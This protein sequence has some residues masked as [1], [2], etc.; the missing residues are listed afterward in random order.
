MPLKDDHYVV[1]YQ[2]IDDFRCIRPLSEASSEGMFGDAS[3]E[4]KLAHEQALH[5]ELVE[6]FK[7]AGW[8]GDGEIKC[9]FIAPCFTTRGDTWCQTVYHV[10]Q[11]NNGTSWLAIPKSLRFQLPKGFMSTHK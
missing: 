3:T 9:I 6:L 11:S 10:K 2:H 1:D 8:E 5:D 7:E 4:E